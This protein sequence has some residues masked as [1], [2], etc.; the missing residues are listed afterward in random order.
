MS[1]LEKKKLSVSITS[2]VNK[3]SSGGNSNVSLLFII[4]GNESC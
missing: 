2:F 1:L 3:N 4:Q